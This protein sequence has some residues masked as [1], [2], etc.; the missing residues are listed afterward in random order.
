MGCGASSEKKLNDKIEKD[1]QLQKEEMES[2]VKL[3]LLGLSRYFF[4]LFLFIYAFYLYL[5]FSITIFLP[6]I[7]TCFFVIPRSW[8]VR[9]EHAEQAD[10]GDPP[11]RVHDGGARRVPHRG[12][13]QRHIMHQGHRKGGRGLRLPD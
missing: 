3:L 13:Q 1:L 11:E 4:F 10:E 12:A 2:E 5:S 9:Q 8:R 6:S 7:Q